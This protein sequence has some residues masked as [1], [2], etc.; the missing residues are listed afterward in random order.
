MPSLTNIVVSLA[1][2]LAISY[3]SSNHYNFIVTGCESNVLCLVDLT[4]KM[5][6]L[7]YCILAD[8][9]Y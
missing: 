5:S 4:I 9:A 2:L 7:Q 3:D 6:G 8:H 1:S